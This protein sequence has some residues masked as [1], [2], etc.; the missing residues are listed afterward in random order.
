M[1][2]IRIRLFLGVFQALRCKLPTYHR[3]LLLLPKRIGVREK[4]GQGK[5]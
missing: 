4:E 2:D 1:G 5:S 3:W